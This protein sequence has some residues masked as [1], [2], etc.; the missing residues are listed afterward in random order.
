MAI[1]I[2]FAIIGKVVTG[3][4]A[5]SRGAWVANIAIEWFPYTNI[6][7]TFRGPYL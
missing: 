4:H 6:W 5:H 3:S 2:N 1:N 7:E